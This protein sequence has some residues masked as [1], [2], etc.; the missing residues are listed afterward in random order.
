[1]KQK[2]RN[3]IPEKRYC[4]SACIH[5]DSMILFGGAKS[6]NSN[7]NTVH[8]LNLKTW[9]WDLLN[10]FGQVPSPRCK[11]SCSVHEGKMYIFGGKS[12]DSFLNDLYSYHFSSNQW[13]K[14]YYSED[15]LPRKTHSSIV[16][17][18]G[19]YI[20]GG[21]VVKHD[22]GRQYSND[23]LRFDFHHK[24]WE[25]MKYNG[26]IECRALHSCIVT[27]DGRMFVFGGCGNNGQFDDIY[28]FQLE[29]SIPNIQNI[30]FIDVIFM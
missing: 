15:L 24:R 9:K 6:V 2:G 1:M 16:Y 13:E 25:N 11:H 17:N 10:N 29:S 8:S 19:M 30:N 23:F 26:E 27:R 21:E 12:E 18:N 22:E 20:F 5:G 28:E 4:H 14:I 3:H 7:F